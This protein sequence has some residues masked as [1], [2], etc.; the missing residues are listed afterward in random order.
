MESRVVEEDIGLFP[1][2][3]EIDKKGA[4]VVRRRL[5]QEHFYIKAAIAFLL[6]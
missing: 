1:R 5:Q 6:T 3:S 4:H 2:D